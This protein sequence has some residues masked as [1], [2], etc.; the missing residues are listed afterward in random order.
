MHM[1]REHHTRSRGCR[2]ARLSDPFAPARS[3]AA[4]L[5][6]ICGPSLDV[7][8]D[9]ASHRLAGWSALSPPPPLVLEA[10]LA[11]AAGRMA[12]DLARSTDDECPTAFASSEGWPFL[13]GD[14]SR[15]DDVDEPPAEGAS[16]L[17]WLRGRCLVEDPTWP[18][19]R[20]LRE[21]RAPAGRDSLL[22]PTALALRWRAALRVACDDEVGASDEARE[23]GSTV[24][25]SDS[26]GATE[27]H[28]PPDNQP[29]DEGDVSAAAADAA[30]ALQRVRSMKYPSVHC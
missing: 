25:P 3:S 16:T 27:V 28:S 12:A 21:A 9:C 13:G 20:A 4:R 22:K 10:E 11:D 23:L 7:G 8:I 18:A 29:A 19:A 24:A 15:D 30:S 17:S 14:P 5:K 6:E 2:K 26:E 1:F